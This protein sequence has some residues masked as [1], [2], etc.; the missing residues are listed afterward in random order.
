MARSIA[1][2]KTKLQCRKNN[3]VRQ[4]GK[5]IFW[6]PNQKMIRVLGTHVVDN[7]T[8]VVASME[9]KKNMGA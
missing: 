4:P 5:L 9:R 2:S 1:E 7:I 8:S 6:G 3:W